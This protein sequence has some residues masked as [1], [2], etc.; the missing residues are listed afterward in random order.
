MKYTKLIVS[1]ILLISIFSCDKSTTGPIVGGS[2]IGEW[3]ES[4]A[5]INLSLTTN[6][7][8]QATNFLNSTGEIAVSGD[9]N[10]KLKL[11]LYF[12]G[13]EEDDPNLTLVN[14]G[15]ATDTDTSYTLTL[16]PTEVDKNGDLDVSVDD[17]TEFDDYLTNLINYTFNETTLNITNSTVN[18]NT[19]GKSATLNGTI[20][21]DKVNIPANQATML[22]LNSEHFY[23]FGNTITTFY[24]DSTFTSSE[25]T[26]AGDSTGTWTIIGDT[27]KITVEMEVEDPDT[28]EITYVDTTLSFIYI[29]YGNTFNISQSF[30]ICEGLPAEGTEDETGC[31]D[32]L[33]TIEFLFGLDEGSLVKAELIYQ[34][35][36]EKI[37]DNQV[38]KISN[39]SKKSGIRSMSTDIIQF[40][41][42]NKRHIQ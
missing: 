38:A 16:D 23:D 15:L 27:L 34:L 4:N 1:I 6:S 13:D 40:L 19:T 17:A 20:S 11:M 41:I 36:F 26:E 24:E 3:K 28:E 9:Y 39:N 10:T 32:V 5:V 29:N 8:Q 25:S 37:P 22:S 21:L 35:F 12:K 33:N 2:I 18:S 30:D 42:N 7:A 31:D 14:M